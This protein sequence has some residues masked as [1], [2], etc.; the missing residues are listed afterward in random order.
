[1]PGKEKWKEVVSEAIQAREAVRWHEEVESKASLCEYRRVKTSLRRE[2]YLRCERWERQGVVLLA[3]L[4]GGTNALAE[5]QGRKNGVPRE[6]RVCLV[7][8]SGEVE[9]TLHFFGSVPL[10]GGEEERD[11]GAG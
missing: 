9:D 11:V 7:C 1:M 4:R 6:E 3:R 2:E 5:S 10:S 8:G